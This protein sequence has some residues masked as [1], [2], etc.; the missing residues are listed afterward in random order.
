MQHHDHFVAVL[1]QRAAQRR[2]QQDAPVHLQPRHAH[3]LGRLDLPM[4]RGLQAAGEDFRGVGAGVDGERQARAEGGIG[5]IGPEHALT[6]RLELRQA[7]VDEEQLHQHRRAADHIG[8]EP[9]R[10]VQPR[11]AGHPQQSQWNG[12]CQAGCQGDQEGRQGDQDTT[13]VERQVGQDQV[14]V[15]VH[16]FAPVLTGR[17]LSCRPRSAFPGSAASAGRGWS[18]P[19]KAPPRS[20]R[21]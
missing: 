6:H 20:G 14:V 5:Q 16:G 17:R 4:G 2:G 10:S 15:E 18:A 8:V 12:Q 1:R 19:G 7:V 13:E 21:R 3:R 9:G 11:R